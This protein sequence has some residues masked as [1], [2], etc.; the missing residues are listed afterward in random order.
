MRLAPHLLSTHLSKSPSTLYVLYGPE[1]FLTDESAR[2]IR[3][4]FLAQDH[5]ERI[6]F[7]CDGTS[8]PWDAIQQALQSPS[9]FSSTQLIELHVQKLLPSDPPKILACIERLSPQ[10]TC[11]IQCHPNL[12]TV[13]KAKWLETAEKKGVVIA[14]FPLSMAQFQQWIGARAKE[15]QLV[16]SREMMAVL[17][18]HTQ[19]NCLAAA[20]EIARLQLCHTDTQ[21]PLTIAELGF[22]NQFEVFDLCEA[23]LLR[24]R[25]RIIQIL[26]TLKV[27][28]GIAL[29]LILW[30]LAQTLRIGIQFNSLPSPE[31]KT[32][33]LY[34]MG[35]RKS[36]HA[37]YHSTAPQD[38]T[39][40]QRLFCRLSEI[41]RQLKSGELLTAWDNTLTV[42]LTMHDLYTE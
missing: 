10:Q 19:G 20:Q 36:S 11:L 3:T 7:Q 13:H 8:T 39:A 35:I 33:L 18:T 40:C 4:R 24:Q 31:Q 1:S 38:V 34:Q 9:L 12:K 6:V 37:L 17:S 22:Q 29:S 42:C 23:I 16:L 25:D 21:T 26:G 28:Q 2:H 15:A 27:T 14:H 30:V 5:S 32:R 41:D